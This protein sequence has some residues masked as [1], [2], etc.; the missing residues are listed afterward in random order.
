TLAAA[1]Q[2]DGQRQRQGARAAN[3]GGALRV[4]APIEAGR[5][6]DPEPRR[7]RRF[8][9]AFAHIE[10]VAARR[11]PPIDQTRAILGPVVAILP[12]RPG[13]AGAAA[14]VKSWRR[15]SEASRIEEYAGQIAR[16]RQRIEARGVGLC[17][18]AARS[19][20]SS[21]SVSM[22]NPSARAPNESCMRCTSA[23]R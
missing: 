18:Q 6:I 4:G 23:G 13:L 19:A 22:S 14:S 3:L 2:Q 16:K 10:S 17:A 11:T 1:R 12:K 5:R 15:S 20:S 8:A 7:L 21:T 9:L